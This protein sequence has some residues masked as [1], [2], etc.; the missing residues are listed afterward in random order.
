MDDKELIDRLL[1]LVNHINQGPRRRW[2]VEGEVVDPKYT[3]TFYK[4]ALC[5]LGTGLRQLPPK[6]RRIII[7]ELKVN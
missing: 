7:N 3:D 2:A 5:L 1:Q 6:T 4:H